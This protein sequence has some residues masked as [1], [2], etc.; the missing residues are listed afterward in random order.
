M[1]LYFDLGGL[2]NYFYRA[3]SH[4][5]GADKIKGRYKNKLYSFDEMK[6]LIK[7]L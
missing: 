6:K 2:F 4:K 7:K 3:Y 5:R 1:K